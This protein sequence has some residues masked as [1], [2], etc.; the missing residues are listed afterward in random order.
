MA[1][2]S[3]T[4]VSVGNVSNSAVAIGSRARASNISRNRGELGEARAM[5]N[6]LVALLGDEH[7]R[8][9]HKGDIQSE[10]LAV[11]AELDNNRPNF[12]LLRSALKGIVTS[13]GPVEALA[14]IGTHV[15][16]IIQ[17]LS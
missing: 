13:L 9:A 16:E 8:I 15:L 4:E 14:S 12:K 2:N 7:L 6:E 10:V 3:K 5:I 17:R 11:Q 1:K